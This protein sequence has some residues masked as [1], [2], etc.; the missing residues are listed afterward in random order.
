MKAFLFPALAAITLSLAACGGE[1][2]DFD[3]NAPADGGTTQ[4]DFSKQYWDGS[5][6]VD[7]TT[8]CTAGQVLENGVCKNS[9]HAC[10][11]NTQYW[12]GT[13]CVNKNTSCSVG[14]HLENGTCVPDSSNPT[15]S[16]VVRITGLQAVEHFKYEV[17]AS[18]SDLGRTFSGGGSHTRSGNEITIS[19]PY[20]GS[21]AP[22]L[23]FSCWTGTTWCATDYSSPDLN[24][25]GNAT[26]NGN[27]RSFEAISVR[28]N[29][30]E[31]LVK[32]GSSQPN[33]P[34][35]TN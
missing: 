32:F 15:G 7:K 30:A 23:R 28:P 9:Q 24:I 12:D 1:V 2:E 13:Q 29:N 10:N 33:L 4:C 8:G 18:A 21:S 35:Q 25:S 31:V 19:I 27:V 26:W 3:P 14:Y 20:T 17:A 5:K 6:C 11:Y 34:L 16:I 22:Y